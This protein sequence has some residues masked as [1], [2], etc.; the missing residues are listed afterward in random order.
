MLELARDVKLL[1]LYETCLRQV[2]RRSSTAQD[3]DM[4]GAQ[5]SAS[6]QGMEFMRESALVFHGI[7]IGSD[8]PT[9]VFEGYTV[10]KALHPTPHNAKPKWNIR[11][12]AKRGGCRQVWSYGSCVSVRT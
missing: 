3:K 4:G 10:E 6:Q 2:D 7:L 12:C 11:E 9:I 8:S 1:L 5:V